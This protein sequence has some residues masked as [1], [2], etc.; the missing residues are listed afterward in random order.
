MNLEMIKKEYEAKLQK[1]YDELYDLIECAVNYDELID[2]YE[3][4]EDIDTYELE[5]ND[6]LDQRHYDILEHKFWIVK[7]IISRIDEINAVGDDEKK[8]HR[9]KR[10]IGSL[11]TEIRRMKKDSNEFIEQE[12]QMIN[13]VDEALGVL[14]EVREKE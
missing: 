8:L 6:A 10:D 7:N 2:T 14:D 4:K 13:Y 9:A 11:V 3:T 1:I 5:W 12:Q